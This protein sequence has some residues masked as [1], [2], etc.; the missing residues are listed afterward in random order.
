[1]SSI[2]FSSISD[3]LGQSAKHIAEK[4]AADEL[5]R[6]SNTNISVSLDGTWQKRGFTSLNGTVA[7]ISMSTGKVIDVGTMVRYCKPCQQ[8]KDTLTEHEFDM[9]FV[10]HKSE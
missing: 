9:W 5:R 1:M 8:K 7:A 4:S 3:V 2:N 10:G 6:T